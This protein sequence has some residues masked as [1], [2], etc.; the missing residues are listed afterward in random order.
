MQANEMQEKR[1][2]SAAATKNGKASEELAA[3]SQRLRTEFTDTFA[4]LRRALYIEGQALKLSLVDTGI[5]AVVGIALA[6]TSIVAIVAALLLGISAL[7]RGLAI[8]AQGAWWSDLVLAL[9]IVGLLAAAVV[10]ARRGM[11]KA[12]LART[13]RHLAESVVPAAPETAP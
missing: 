12:V 10:L 1:S 6:I 3:A 9:A 7:R 13:K 8:L 4:L 5:R 11:H 2:R